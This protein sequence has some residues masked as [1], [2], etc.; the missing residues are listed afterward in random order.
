MPL[1]LSIASVPLWQVLLAAVL[2]W[3]S[4]IGAMA[5]AARAFR[6]GMLQYTRRIPFKKL[7]RGNSHE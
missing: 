7:F 5:L 1:R 3:G 2:M 6:V 4:A